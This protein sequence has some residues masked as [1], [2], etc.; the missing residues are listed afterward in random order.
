MKLIYTAN[1]RIPSEKAHPYQIVQM[2]E[3]FADAGVAVTLL[4][5]SRRNLPELCTDDVWGFYGVK[6]NFVAERLWVLDLHPLARHL[7]PLARVWDGLSALLVMLTYNLSLLLRL[8]R[9]RK[10]VIYSRDPLSLVLIAALWP[11]WAGRLFLEV[12]TY[13]ATNIGI[14]LR[15]WLVGRIAGWVVIT[16][17]LRQR[18][19]ALGIPAD[20][21]LVAPD[22]IRRARFEVKGDRTDWRAKIGW[23]VDAFIVGY[24]GRFHTLGMDKGLSDL[25]EAVIL[26]AGD[27][28]AHPVR[29]GLVGGPAEA[30]E[31]LRARFRT[32]GLP[33]EMVLYAGQVPAT[34]VPNYLRAFDVCA[35]PFPWT[36]HFAYYASPMKLFEYMASGVPIVATDLPSTAEIIRNGENGLLTPPSDPIGLAGALRRLRHDPELARRLADQAAR[37]VGNYTWDA[38]ARRI[39][40]LIERASDPSCQDGASGV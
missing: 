19:E 15:R 13:P 39:L 25:V 1:A 28:S 30:V 22:G 12:H 34:A 31:G 35:M 11:R 36:E 38:R 10:A 6:R 3:A 26:L 21:L 37:D 24:M 27:Q 8:P 23:P 9:E 18:Y 17:H 33:D 5:A 29:L 4:Y 2:C 20:R 14:W 7:G 16:N 40:G 32:A